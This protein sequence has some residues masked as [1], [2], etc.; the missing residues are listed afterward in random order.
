MDRTR[1]LVPHPAA[2]AL[3]WE[4]AGRLHWADPELFPPFSSVLATAW[5]LLDEADFRADIRVTLLACALAF[6]IVAPLALA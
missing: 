6:A 1:L 5:R 4:L 2:L 3:A